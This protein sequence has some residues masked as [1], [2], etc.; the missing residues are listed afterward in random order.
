MTSNRRVT[1]ATAHLSKSVSIALAGLALIGASAI[2]SPARAGDVP[3]FAVDASWP[4]PLPNTGS[5]ARS[6]ASPWMR[7]AISG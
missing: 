6:A 7:K 5:S 4:K 2:T 1:A 3:T